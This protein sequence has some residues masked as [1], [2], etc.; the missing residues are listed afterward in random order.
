MTNVVILHTW[1]RFAQA[2]TFCTGYYVLHDAHRVIMCCVLLA[3]FNAVVF[4][5]KKSSSAVTNFIQ[6]LQT[7]AEAHGFEV[8]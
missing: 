5:G 7:V 1:L 2:V 4:L 3:M 8:T 6:V